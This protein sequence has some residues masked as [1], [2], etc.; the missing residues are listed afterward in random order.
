MQLARLNWNIIVKVTG[1]LLVI[2]GLFVLSCLPVSLYFQ[3]DDFKP[4]LLSGLIILCTGF[5]FWFINRKA[6][7]NDVSKKESY[8]IVALIWI[9]ISAFGALPYFISGY[10]P[11]YTDAFFETM[12]GFST[13]GASIL[14]DIE[15]IPKG[16]LYW[17]SLTCWMGGMGIIV[18]AVAIL[19]FF[20]FGGMNILQAEAPGLT[21]DK[22]HPRI[23]IVARRFLGIY[24]GLTV[25]EII[26]LK[27]GGMPLYDAVSH[28][29]CTIATAGFSPKNTSFVQYSPFIQY[30]VI[31][32]MM[33][34]GTNFALH[35]FFIKGQFSKVYKNE[36]FLFYLCILFF[37]AF[38]IAIGL[39]LTNN[40]NFE[41]SFRNSLFQVVSIVT[42]TGFI[43]NDYMTWPS[44]L[45]FLLF[46]L[47]FS[48]GMTGSTAGSLKCMRHIILFKNVRSIFFKLIHPNAWLP[49]K[50]MGKV[51]QRDVIMSILALFVIYMSTFA[52]GVFI[53]VSFGLDLVDS[54]GSVASCMGN[55]GPGLGST[56][57]IG[58]YAHLPYVSKWTLS[59]L[60]LMGR[61]EFFSFLVVFSPGFWK[62]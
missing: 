34:G 30:V 35:Y 29:F 22:L 51:V 10:I 6:N 45:W 36:E 17:R 4:L 55:I 26:L 12:S 59:A 46:L 38:F 2:E 54:C 49:V 18:L 14:K 50:Y 24:I 13:T 27:V 11:S 52:I 42:C 39:F 28:S 15:V 9:I 57:G 47:M 48:G 1:I 56:G 60:M 25:L 33:L 19:P 23:I 41:K 20:G 40:L 21:K 5:L 3:G 61:L 7:P 44:Y 8:L 16:L 53:L 58:N 43:S 62:K 32:F 37:S 31:F